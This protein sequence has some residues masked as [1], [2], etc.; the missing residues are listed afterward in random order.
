L[1]LKWKIIYSCIVLKS[2]SVENILAEN[3][4]KILLY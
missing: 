3:F 1:P 4:S 2:I